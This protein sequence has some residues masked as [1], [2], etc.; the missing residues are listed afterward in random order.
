MFCTLNVLLIIGWYICFFVVAQTVGEQSWGTVRFRPSWPA[1]LPVIS[2][3]LFLLARKA[4]LADEKLVRSVDR[5][6]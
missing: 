2:L 6:R 3:I 4:I 5:I 1:V